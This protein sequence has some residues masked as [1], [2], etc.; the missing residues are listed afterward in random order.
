MRSNAVLATYRLQTSI[1]L[2]PSPIAG[3]TLL[4]FWDLGN[5]FSQH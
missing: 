1:D 5:P 2:S 4:F 3:L